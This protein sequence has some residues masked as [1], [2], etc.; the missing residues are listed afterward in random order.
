[1]STGKLEECNQDLVAVYRQHFEKALNATNLGLLV[2][3]YI[4][5]NDLNIVRELDPNKKK[6]R[7]QCLKFTRYFHVFTVSGF[8][9]RRRRKGEMDV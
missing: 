1:M 6:V 9:E 4:R 5:R 8:S 3:A 2:D 7:R